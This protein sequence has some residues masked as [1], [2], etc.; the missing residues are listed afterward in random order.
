MKHP[1]HRISQIKISI[2][3]PHTGRDHFQKC[4]SIPHHISIHAPHTGR[5]LAI[6]F[7]LFRIG[8]FQST[9]PIRGATGLALGVHH[10]IFLFQSTRPIR[11]AT[12]RYHQTR[13]H[14]NHFNP[15]AP[16]GARLSASLILC[17]IE[18]ISIHAPHTGRDA[19]LQ[20][21]RLTANRN[22]NPRAPYGARQPCF[23]MIG[24]PQLFQST[25]PI[26]GA[27]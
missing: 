11:G 5:D 14:Y 12:N 3:A 19:I 6:W 13:R 26:R 9:R 16:Y 2:H 24:S 17:L 7:S 20:D 1:K 25:R 27:T 23:R 21:H 18:S 10:T 8:A 4:C 22:F 15:R